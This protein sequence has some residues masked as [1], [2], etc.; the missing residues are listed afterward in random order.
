MRFLRNILDKAEI[1]FS[2]G[3]KYEKLWPLFDAPDTF[4]FS[5]DKIAKKAPFISGHMTKAFFIE[6]EDELTIDTVSYTHLTLPTI[7]SV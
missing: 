4:L 1:Y 3:S 2:K 7:Y 5:T 6:H